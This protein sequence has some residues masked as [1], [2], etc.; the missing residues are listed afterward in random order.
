MVCTNA[1]A[2]PQESTVEKSRATGR[3][4][5]LPTELRGV[6]D[7][8]LTS[9]IT[10]ISTIKRMVL[11]KSDAVDRME[12]QRVSNLATQASGAQV[13]NRVCM[14]CGSVDHWMADCAKSKE[15]LNA[16]QKGKG[17]GKGG[18]CFKCQ[19]PGHIA[20][21]CKAGGA[22]ASVAQ[23]LCASAAEQ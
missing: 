7:M 4:A 18:L 13:R 19:K 6:G 8:C 23:L 1:E 22:E 9:N 5:S 20:R 2:R 21:Y 14:F 17:A 12:V 3:H 11:E 10:D 16:A 15:T